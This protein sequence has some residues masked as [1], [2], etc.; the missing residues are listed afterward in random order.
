MCGRYRLSRRKQLVTEYFDAVPHDADWNPRYNIAPRQP[1]PIIRQHP[2]EPRREL[3]LVR[4]GLIPSWAKDASGAAGMINARSESAAIKPAFRD[5]LKSR[6]CLIPADGFYEWLRTGKTKQPYCFEVN[7]GALFAFAG[8]WE[9]WKD[10]SG[11]WIKSC[12]IL[13]TTPNAVTAAVH[14]R[15]PVIL[16]PD[17]YD[18]WLDPG[19]TNVTAVS[20]MLKPYDARLMRSYPVST[21]INQA[22][23]DDAECAKPVGIEAP[24]QGRLFA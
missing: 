23:N 6:R 16:H 18:L 15:M 3:S 5:A 9:R 13:T 1:V 17:N 10:P 22:A 20:E 11:N 24:T 14:D 8:L 4:W 12:S 2:K 21:R 19:F 7:E